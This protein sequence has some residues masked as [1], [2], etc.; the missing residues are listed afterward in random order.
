MPKE[1]E[2]KSAIV[3]GSAV[4][5]AKEGCN[6][7][8]N[9]AG[10][11]ALAEDVVKQC[12]A[13]GVKAIA[14]QADVAKIEQSKAMVDRTIK[15]FGRL[16]ILV[17]NA[18]LGSGATNGKLVDLTPERYDEA[19]GINARGLFFMAQAAARVMQDGGRIINFS[20]ANTRICSPNISNYVGT[21]SAVE[22]WTRV[23]AN[24]LG[25]RKITVNTVSPGAVATDMFKNSDKTTGG[26][27]SRAAMSQTPLKRIADPIDIA[28]VVT[29][30]CSE[31]GSWVNGQNL[32][33]GLVMFMM[34]V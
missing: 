17:N 21:K 29:F 34:V 6:V 4:E 1:L 16:D 14:V 30:L 3:T 12:Q 10:S 33:V 7:V 11:K 24:E 25:G 20:S 19:F 22:G 13:L 28:N 27:M 5:L 2:G 9:Y 8:V 15:E 26:A 31:R 18:A 23:W 32:N